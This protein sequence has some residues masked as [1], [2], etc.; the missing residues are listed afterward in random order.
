VLQDGGAVSARR[1]AGDMAALLLVNA[2]HTRVRLVDACTCCARVLQL[3][4]ACAR[5][6]QARTHKARGVSQAACN[7]LGV[8]QR[9]VNVS[10]GA[11]H[12]GAVA[13]ALCTRAT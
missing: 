7:V 3:V 1:V 4:P 12:V 2:L 5:V 13:R 9:G 8:V 10:V 6:E 11:E